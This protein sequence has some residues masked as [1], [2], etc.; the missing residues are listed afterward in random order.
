[1]ET[2]QQGFRRARS[3]E[4]KQQRADGL[5]DAARQLAHA[6]GVRTVT[7]T[8]IANTAG[9]HVS[10]VRRYFESR[11]EIFLRLAEEGW[12]EWAQALRL[13][14]DT[15][16]SV[17]P[18][19]LAAVLADSLSERPLFCDLLAH[20]P[21]SLER[22]VSADVVRAFKLSALAA[23][24]DIA[25]SITSAFPDLGPGAARDLVTTSMAL[26]Q[27]LW[28]IAHPPPTLAAL[29]EE[30]D[31]LAHAGTE[32]GPALTRLLHACVLGLTAA[33]TGVSPTAV[34]HVPP[35]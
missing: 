34:A 13:R 32:F 12:Q 3:P 9:V 22:G 2:S 21:L 35:G 27:S 18:F 29:Y 16:A 8:E 25:G 20:A 23:A 7:L 26:A 31:R 4:R 30:D 17:T 19:G 15:E 11:E 5:L 33:Q 24:R 10:A 28:Q 6:G 1:M 14:L